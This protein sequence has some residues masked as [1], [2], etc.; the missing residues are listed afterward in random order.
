MRSGRT[1]A[2]ESAAPKVAGHPVAAWAATLLAAGL[3]S[4]AGC[5][6][7]SQ[8]S[9]QN[10]AVEH[11]G[12]DG[13]TPLQWAVYNQNVAQ[14][15]RLLRAGANPNEAND[16]GATP[17]SL[18]AE[19][20]NTQIIETLLAAGASPES[21][22]Q[23]GQTALM[24]VARTGNLEAAKALLRH[25][26]NVNAHEQWR[27]QTA[28][29][30]A[31]ARQKPKMME[32]LIAH[33]A[34]I[35]ARS[36]IYNYERHITAEGRAKSEDTGG[37]TP[38]IFAAREDCLACVNVLIAHHVNINLPDPDGFAPVTIAIENANWDIAKRLILAGCDVNQWDIYGQGPL[39]AAIDKGNAEGNR[40]SIDPPNQATSHDIIR[41]LLDRGANPNMQL[42]FRP[43]SAGFG[44]GGAQRGTTPLIRAAAEG[45]VTIV[46]MLLAHGADVHLFQADHETPIIAAVSGG[47]G[48]GGG[49]GGGGGG[50]ARGSIAVLR[51]LFAAGAGSDVN[52][53]ALRHALNRTRGGTALHYATRA[54]NTRA[55]A[56]L[57]AH[58]A[59]VNAKD[60][61]GLT[62]LDYAMG[63]GYVP[64]LQTKHSPE[65][66]LVKLLKSSGAT[67][68]LTKTPYWPPQ[69]PPLG[70]TVYSPIIWPL[71]P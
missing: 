24:L 21:P 64:F 33:G 49:F 35:N 7:V 26:A 55:I 69:G 16:Y 20:G 5:A 29:M 40:S 70:Y 53:L 52:V 51:M 71:G 18:A 66:D 37:L 31:A 44:G 67:V 34:D 8:Q 57:I 47:G 61:D 23:D 3:L 14:V 28:L 39:F 9:A 11:R 48:R 50:G 38:L 12:P 2:A 46:K 13:S 22:N 27:G 54:H 60:L 41:L 68:Q 25:G 63:R 6:T 10:A 17:M 32:L 30:W 19:V 15:K 1:I 62:A 65:M 42:F 59:N 43:K 36:A 45:D 58:G 4:L 56:F